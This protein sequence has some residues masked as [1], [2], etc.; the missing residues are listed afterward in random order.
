MKL[1]QFFCEKCPPFAR[2]SSRQFG[3]IP[4][5]SLRSSSRYCLIHLTV[6]HVHGA[7]YVSQRKSPVD[8]AQFEILGNAKTVVHHRI[9][10]IAALQ[11]LACQSGEEQILCDCFEFADACVLVDWIRPE[12]EHAASNNAG[13]PLKMNMLRTLSGSRLPIA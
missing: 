9:A 6:L 3:S 13:V 7:R 11:I 10:D 2:N 4:A 12:C 8:A 5:V 1:V